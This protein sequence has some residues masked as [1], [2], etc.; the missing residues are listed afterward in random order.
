MAHEQAHGKERGQGSPY[1]EVQKAQQQKARQHK[2]QQHKEQQQKKQE[3]MLEHRLNTMNQKALE[4]AVRGHGQHGLHGISQLRAER[5]LLEKKQLQHEKEERGQ[6]TSPNKLEKTLRGHFQHKSEKRDKEEKQHEQHWSERIPH[7]LEKAEQKHAP[8]RDEKQQKHEQHGHQQ[9][10]SE[11]RPNKL[12]KTVREHKPPGDEKQQKQEHQKHEPHQNESRPNKLE[13]VAREHRLSQDEKQQKSETQFPREKPQHS[14]HDLENLTDLSKLPEP[15]RK[16]IQEEARM[17]QNSATMRDEAKLSVLYTLGV[18]SL[19]EYQKA[20]SAPYQSL[21][22]SFFGVDTQKPW[23]EESMTRE[24]EQ[25]KPEQQKPEQRSREAPNKLEKAVREHASQRSEQ[26]Q[27]ADVA[28]RVER[29]NLPGPSSK[30]PEALSDHRR[31]GDNIPI[32]QRTQGPSAD[33]ASRA[34]RTELPNASLAQID[35]ANTFDRNPRAKPQASEQDHQ[36][37]PQHEHT[38]SPKE[39]EER[40][41]IATPADG[42]GFQFGSAQLVPGMMEQWLASQPESLRIALSDPATKVIITASA[43]RPGSEETNLRLSEERTAS[44]QQ[45]LREHGVHAEIVTHA[46]GEELAKQAGKSDRADDASDRVAKI[47]VIPAVAKAETSAPFFR[48]HAHAPEVPKDPEENFGEELAKFGIEHSVEHIVSDKIGEKLVGEPGGPYVG[49]L[50]EVARFQVE[51]LLK[52]GEANEAGTKEMCLNKYVSE[53][54]TAVAKLT[55]AN[56]GEATES[57]QKEQGLPPDEFKR[58]IENMP[59]A[60][61]NPNGLTQALDAIAYT[62]HRDALSAVIQLGEKG[63]QKFRNEYPDYEARRQVVLPVLYPKEGREK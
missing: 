50:I 14:W 45:W 53:Y 38:L 3:K 62:A 51:A 19:D 41:R 63:V 57:Y 56:P 34:E 24:S 35:T 40:L 17:I 26:Q 49:S 16:S 60:I 29:S 46:L 33:A 11:S 6:S 54:A 48:D 39:R 25:Q 52:L 7:E 23:K 58:L 20:L 4:K 43:S 32:N 22:Q 37:A 2:E 5:K 8:S 15:V 21:L 61:L 13:K 31:Q 1:P 55:Q 12:E 44:V 27:M 36:V 47:E 42:V 30:R 9:H 28:S 10:R 59:S 18:I